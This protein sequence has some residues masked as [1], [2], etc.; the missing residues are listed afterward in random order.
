MVYTPRNDIQNTNMV[1]IYYVVYVLPWPSLSTLG[2]ILD[3]YLLLYST[4]SYP[5]VAGHQWILLIEV[6]RI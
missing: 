3:S 2:L 6:S 1:Y 5:F 4:F